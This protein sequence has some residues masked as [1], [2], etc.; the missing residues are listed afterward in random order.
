MNRK[1]SADFAPEVLQHFDAYVHGAL[2]RRGFLVA[3]AQYATGALTA[4]LIL[5]Q[6]SPQFAA[7]QQIKPDDGRLKAVR[8]E[9]PSPAGN[10]KVQGYLVETAKPKTKSRPGA[11]LVI[12]ENRGLNP[13]IED[14]ARRLA[15][16]G[17]LVFAP[18][19]LAPLGG[20]PGDEDKARELFGQLDQT[21]TRADLVA[22]AK[23]LAALPQGNGKL[24]VVGF[25]YGGGM[26]NYLAT[27]LPELDAA[28]PFYG[29]APDLKDVAA[30]KAP[31][32][33][34]FAEKDDRVNATWPPY[35]AALKEH[36]KKFQAY[37]YAGTQH[38][39]NN[40]TTPRYDKDAA[41]LAWD[42]TVAFFREQLG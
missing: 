1:T 31:L 33:L 19:A 12:H 11:V 20:Y 38:G 17:F 21:R 9:F 24:G 35:E 26:T 40:D 37:T 2:S 27:Q 22:A 6:L 32:L 4:E 16:E 7:A 14:I 5:Q 10:G 15:L 29:P 34:Q 39:F 36:G 13:H 18:D 41:R 23:G 8:T 28:V 3:I 25:C 42:R 30:I